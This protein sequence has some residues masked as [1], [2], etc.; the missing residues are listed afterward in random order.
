MTITWLPTIFQV[1]L[2]SA[3]PR[4]SH[5]FCAAPSSVRPGRRAVGARGEELV[6][7]RLVVAV[8][9]LVEQEQLRVGADPLGAVDA[10]GVAGHAQARHVLEEG[11]EAA[12]AALE[13]RHARVLGG[14]ARLVARPVV[15]DL[16]VVPDREQRVGGAERAQVGVGV[17]ERVLVAV[18]R[19]RLD[20]GVA[21]GAGLVLAHRLV[22]VVLL[23]DVVA[24]A[25]HEVQV[26]LVRQRGVGGVVAGLVV[27]AGEE[28]DPGG[29]ARVG[30][31]R[32][33]EAPDG[34]VDRAGD[35]AVVVALAR[36]E[37]GVLGAVVDRVAVAPRG[38][39][40]PCGRSRGGSRRP[41]R[42]RPAGGRRA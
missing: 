9:A 18:L 33:G 13:E 10:V 2:E 24:E 40:R 19:Q 16:V 12:R 14:R 22:V 7:A 28:G 5:S 26:V 17:V 11:L 20:L 6:A 4:S 36:L 1:A 38:R 30:R 29:L 15:L 23:V 39:R 25:D 34:A 3:R 8:G 32:G 42:S 41:V 31:P 21:V 27:L 35:E 37:H